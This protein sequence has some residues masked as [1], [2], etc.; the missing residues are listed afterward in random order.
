L[1]RWQ[2]EERRLK[3]SLPTMFKA[4]INNVCVATLVASC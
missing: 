4:V 2:E 1:K 3:S